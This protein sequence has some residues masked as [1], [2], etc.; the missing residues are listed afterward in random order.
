MT[1]VLLVDDH[2]DN[3][4]YLATLL[5][6]RGCEVEAARHGAEALTL[7][8]QTPPDLVVSDLL[9][10]VMDGYTLLRHWKADARLSG[11]PFIVYTAT[12]TDPEDERLA[13]DLGADA[14]ILKPAEPEPFWERLEE[15]LERAARGE[16]A[17]PRRPAIAAE[18][19]HE[20]YDRALVRKLEARTGQLER[21]NLP[22]RARRGRARPRGGGAAPVVGGPRAARPRAH[23]CS[24]RRRTH[25]LEAFAYSVS[26]DLRAPLR[27]IDGYSGI[28]M[29]D[30]SAGLGDE[31]RRLCAVIRERAE[32]MAT[33]IDELLELS[34]VG[35]VEL[36]PALLETRAMVGAVYD[37][38]DHGG[39]SVP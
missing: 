10:P 13:L 31:G 9:M 12:Y 14:F 8:R 29:E 37:G 20:Q 18:E 4:L 33:M 27:A 21:L 25:E 17:A 35:R 15:V 32:R 39:S 26:H 3:L 16:L 38:R 11:V 22:A 24:W 30:F 36:E 2:E 7:A 6:A 23:R 1:R 5:V 19:A 28:L 34:R